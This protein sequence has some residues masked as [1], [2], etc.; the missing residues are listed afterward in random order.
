MRA[1]SY[2]KLKAK[3]AMLEKQVQILALY[4]DSSEA[5]QIKMV[6][7]VNKDVE[8]MVWAGEPQEY[9]HQQPYDEMGK[10]H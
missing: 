6:I 9:T 2:Q 4:P 5:L 3:M 1:N 7:R 8:A 10:R